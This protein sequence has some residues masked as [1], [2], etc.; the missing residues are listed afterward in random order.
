MKGYFLWLLLCFFLNFSV[1]ADTEE[2]IPEKHY[3]TYI[4]YSPIDLIDYKRNSDGTLDVLE[5]EVTSEGIYWKT[6]IQGLDFKVFYSNE[7]LFRVSHVLASSGGLRPSF[8]TR[9]K[10]S[11]S[12]YL[13]TRSFI[14]KGYSWYEGKR[15]GFHT[16]VF[17]PRRRHLSESH[18]FKVDPNNSNSEAKIRKKILSAYDALGGNSNKKQDPSNDSTLFVSNEVYRAIAHGDFA[19]H[20]RLAGML[21]KDIE[22]ASNISADERV[23][24]INL[25]LA[26]DIRH[27][28]TQITELFGM[29]NVVRFTGNIPM[30]RDVLDGIQAEKW[31][32]VF[33]TIANGP[34]TSPSLIVKAVPYRVVETLANMLKSSYEHLQKVNRIHSLYL[35]TTN[36]AIPR[37]SK[38]VASADLE[39]FRYVMTPRNSQLDWS[40]AHHSE[41]IE[42]LAKVV[43]NDASTKFEPVTFRLAR[44]ALDQFEVLTDFSKEGCKDAMYNFD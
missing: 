22:S 23:S 34:E 44:K 15:T 40:K 30:I 5:F 38:T 1:F 28:V 13:Q 36:P 12:K 41:L 21:L 24:F 16:F 9:T 7:E 19:E 39:D 11:G 26:H 20:R 18:F 10:V 17:D 3:G 4:G 37:F 32:N 43:R 35:D 29:L 14:F 42:L 33:T 27:E 6:K 31:K 25:W 8:E 2:R